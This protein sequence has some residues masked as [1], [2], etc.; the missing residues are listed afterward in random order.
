MWV[1]GGW[2]GLSLNENL[3]KDENLCFVHVLVS[4]FLIR[5]MGMDW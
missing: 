5:L 2:G 1:V 4:L 3:K